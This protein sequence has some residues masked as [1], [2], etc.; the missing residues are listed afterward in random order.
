MQELYARRASWTSS[1]VPDSWVK[2]IWNANLSKGERKE[3]RR[4][5]DE[6]DANCNTCVHLVRVANNKSTDGGFLTGTCEHQDEYPHP[7]KARE[8][9]G[10]MLFHPNDF[11]GMPCH[12]LRDKND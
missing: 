11:M 1:V 8:R 6:L 7:Y 4:C 3:S 2:R 5:F 10:V 9:N 12:K